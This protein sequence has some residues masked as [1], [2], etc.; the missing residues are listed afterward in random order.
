MSRLVIFLSRRLSTRR[1][2][3]SSPGIHHRVVAMFQA[4]DMD[5][6]PHSRRV[7]V[8]VPSSAVVCTVAGPSLC[9][10][11]LFP[12]VCVALSCLGSRSDSHGYRTDL[13]SPQLG[14][15]EPVVIERPGY[16]GNVLLSVVVSSEHQSEC[17]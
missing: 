11:P 3:C 16:R 9:L 1:F 2:H 10:R 14:A 15:R 5:V 12:S 13:V 6:G 4:I 7:G 17:L 8:S